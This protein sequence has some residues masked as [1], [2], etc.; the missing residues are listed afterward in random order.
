MPKH[1][2]RRY[3]GT[4]QYA[5]VL[6][7]DGLLSTFLLYMCMCMCAAHLLCLVNLVN[8]SPNLLTN[9]ENKAGQ[10]SRGGWLPFLG[11]LYG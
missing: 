2:Y 10:P 5:R 8:E 7:L 11:R 3:C 9:A 4:T 6:L 1:T